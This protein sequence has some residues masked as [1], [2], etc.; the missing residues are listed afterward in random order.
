[1]GKDELHVRIKLGKDVKMGRDHTE[2]HMEYSVIIMQV[3][4]FLK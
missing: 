2:T 3:A 1:M 4:L